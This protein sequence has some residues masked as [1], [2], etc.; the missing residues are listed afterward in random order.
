MKNI[1]SFIRKFSF[2]GGKIFSIFEYTCFRGV[3]ILL[4][5]SK[6]R[7]QTV[8]RC[9]LIWAFAVRIYAPKAHFSKAR[10]KFNA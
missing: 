8:R 4:T 7:G 10:L 3:M 5:D 6:D 9:R 2:F 1:R